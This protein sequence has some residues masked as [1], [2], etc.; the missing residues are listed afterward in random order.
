MCCS[1]SIANWRPKLLR[2]ANRD[3][4]MFA[5]KPGDAILTRGGSSEG[6]VQNG[7]T[8]LPIMISYQKE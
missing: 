1:S 5:V 7:V 6:L 4:T 3:V 2:L 8:D